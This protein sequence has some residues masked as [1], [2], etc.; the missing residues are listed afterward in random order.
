MNQQ[1][2]LAEFAADMS[3]V[4]ARLAERLNGN[5]ASSIG[6]EPSVIPPV[7]EVGLGHRQQQVISRL[8][9]AGTSGERTGAIAAAIGVDHP[10]ALLTLRSLEKRGLV[11]LVP[12]VNPQHWR[13]RAVSPPATP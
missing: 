4:F 3:A 1:Q 7:Q 2:A 12:G 9:T 5:E 11:E 13:L 6:A 8:Q 10:N